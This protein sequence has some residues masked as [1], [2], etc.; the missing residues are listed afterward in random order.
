MNK[1]VIFFVSIIAIYLVHMG[2][3]TNTNIA[4]MKM[5]IS[6]IESSNQDMKEQIGEK[7][8]LKKMKPI[9]LSDEYARFLNQVRVIEDYSGTSMNIELEDKTDV[10]DISQQF[11]LSEY[12]GVREL[13]LKI[14]IDKFSKETDMGA[15]LDDIHQLEKFTDF[16]A[17]E[18]NK[19][20]NSLIVKGEVY[21][22]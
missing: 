6:Q 3:D 17:T 12:K 19:D 14:I 20:N 16:K 8:H 2:I 5:Q 11:S 7:Q 21:G 4:D 1:L 10:N 13:K 9:P 22:L 18:I 15:V